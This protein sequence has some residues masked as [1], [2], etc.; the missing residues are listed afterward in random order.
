MRLCLSVFICGSKGFTAPLSLNPSSHTDS[1]TPE[2]SRMVDL[3]LGFFVRAHGFVWIVS[4]AAFDAIV[5]GVLASGS[6]R[7]VVIGGNA[8]GRAQLFVE[9]P[10][11]GKLLHSNGEFRAVV[12][13][14]KLL[15]TRIPE[16][17]ELSLRH[18]RRNNG[19][20]IPAIGSLPQFRAAAVPFDS[21]DASR[22][23]DKEPLARERFN[24]RL[25]K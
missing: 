4:R 15:I 5:D 3:L 21:Y 8:E 16:M 12:R 11:I 22:A 24:L 2:A 25:I 23:A 13:E 19:H 10:Q 7:L 9:Y 17:R 18:D 6:E 20:L 1:L 14:Q